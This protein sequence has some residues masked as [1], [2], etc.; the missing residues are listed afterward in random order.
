MLLRSSFTSVLCPSARV[1]WS[2]EANTPTERSEPNTAAAEPAGESEND[3]VDAD[4]DD[5]DADC[6]ETTIPSRS[7]TEPSASGGVDDETAPTAVLKE[8]ADP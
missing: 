7:N 2:K 8:A 1:A 4:D 3:D 5:D 6:E